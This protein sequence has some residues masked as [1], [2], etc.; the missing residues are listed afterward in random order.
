MRHGFTDRLAGRRVPQLRMMIAAAGCE[1]VALGAE[2][3]GID[4]PLM[5]DNSHRVSQL[6]TPGRQDRAQGGMQIVGIGRGG[7]QGA[8]QPQESVIVLLVFALADAAIEIGASGDPLVLAAG[9]FRRAFLFLGLALESGLPP[10][11]PPRP[12]AIAMSPG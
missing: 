2:G 11:L 9:C 3:D 5:T 4:L 1:V 8:E 12:A 10:G 7:F 6:C